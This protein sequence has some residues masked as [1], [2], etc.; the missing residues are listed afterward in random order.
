ME[1]KKVAI[2]AIVVVILVG[3]FVWSRSGEP[4]GSKSNQGAQKSEAVKKITIAEFGELFIYAPLYIAQEK[5]FFTEQGLDVTVVPTGGDEKTF[6]A[7]LSGDAQFGV[8]DPTFTAISGDKGQPGKVIASVVSRV[9]FWG[10]AKNQNIPVINTPSD[11]KNYSVATFPAPSTAYVLQKK[12][13]QDGGLKSNIKETAFGSL[14]ASLEANQVDIAL[15]LEPNVSMAVNKGD[16]IVYSLA[17]QYPDF[18]FTGLTALPNYIKS[19]PEIVQKVVSAMQKATTYVRNNPV[20]AAEIL[21][22]KF[23]E[24]EKSV[25][26]NAIKNMT[27]MNIFPKD[28]TMSKT[29]WDASIQLRKEMGDIKGTAAYGDYVVTSFSEKAKELVK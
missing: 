11:L 10:V 16:K 18:A 1:K 13:F 22:K 28:I 17:K 23:P 29:S 3:L 25:A 20:G 15:E 8:A 21:T 7:L 24:V 6:A 19:D 26:E 2:I 12:M 9:P 5:G 4:T 14:L 27:E